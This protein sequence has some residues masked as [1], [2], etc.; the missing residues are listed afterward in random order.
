MSRCTI[1]GLTFAV[2]LQCATSFAAENWPQWRGPLGTGVAPAGD[3]PVKFSDSVGVVWKAMLPGIGTS[4]PAV[5]GDRIFVTCGIKGD[6]GKAHDGIL[7]FD[8]HGKELWRHQ[9]GEERHGKNPHGSGSNPSPVTDGEHV[10]VYYKTGTLACLDP[11]GNVKWKV[12]LQERFG[13]DTLWWDLGT[14]PVLADGRAIVAVMQDGDSYLVAID[15]ESGTVA[16]KQKRQYK[17]P[18]ESDQSYST[19][20]VVK[21]DGKDVVVTW[22]ADHLT[23]HDAATG[24]L[25]WECGGFNPED[26]ANWRTIASVAVIDGMAIVPYARG[27]SL[28]GIRIGGSGDITKTARVW[29]K[30]D[31][32]LSADVP[33]P[34]VKDGKIYLLTDKGKISCRDVTTGD[35]LWSAN[36]PANRNKYYAS[37]VLAGEKL[38]CAREDGI[39]YVGSVGEKGFTLLTEDGNDMGGRIIASPVP[40]RGKLLIRGDEN[41]YLIGSDTAAGK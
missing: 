14:S 41:L 31:R 4:T 7:C 29:T 3:Y 18:R 1:F 38:Y 26:V 23:G 21:V 24:K 40:I 27:E 33:T 2:A 20:Q 15:L 35:E 30:S 12:N 5:W 10:V 6:D 16:W 13:K 9:F 32:G 8:M 39:V 22:G 11:A 34:V 28:A 37:P 36:L 17:T 19:P 25:L